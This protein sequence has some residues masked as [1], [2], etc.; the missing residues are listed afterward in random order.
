MRVAIT[1][2]IWAAS[3]SAAMAQESIER[4]YGYAYDLRSGAYRY[5]EVHE[6]TLRDESWLGGTIRYHL[7]DGELFARKSLDF[8]RDP[9]VPEYHFENLIQGYRE[10][11]RFRDGRWFMYHQER[12]EPERIRPFDKS[13]PMAADS[14]FHGYIRTHLAKVANGDTLRFRFVAAGRLDTF[15]FKVEP[16]GEARFEGRPVLKLRAG[17]DSLLSLLAEPLELAYDPR[18]RQLLEYRG[19]SNIQN[20]ATGEPYDIRIAYYS[21]PPADVPKL[22][23]LE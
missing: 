13:G 14:G 6:Q 18:S 21:T 12:N 2:V 4:F 5:T 20:P 11:I 8:S 3:F 19:L 1:M 10:G 17:L 22:P 9:Y 7:P 16:D 15:A 23:P